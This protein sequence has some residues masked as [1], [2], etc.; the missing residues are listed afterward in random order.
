MLRC[1]DPKFVYRPRIY[2][3]QLILTGV[4]LVGILIAED[5]L[6]N[7]AVV[8]SSVPINSVIFILSAAVIIS[9]VRFALCR[10]LLN[11]I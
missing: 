11:L 10:H 7:G 3:A 4:V 2:L 1:I 6:T 5:A 8:A 9:V